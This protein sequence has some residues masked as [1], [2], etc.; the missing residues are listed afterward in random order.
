MAVSVLE[1][2]ARALTPRERDVLRPAS[3]GLPNK[4][5]AFELNLGV[6]TVR[7]HMALVISKLDAVNRTGAV[8]KALRMT[9]IE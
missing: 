2:P 1:L 9:L 8:A 3:N 5:I 6:E 4:S 7:T